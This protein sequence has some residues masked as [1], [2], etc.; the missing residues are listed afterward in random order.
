[1]I[2]RLSHSKAGSYKGKIRR[3]EKGFFQLSSSVRIDQN[4]RLE[5]VM[6]GCTIMTE[7]ISCEEHKPGDFRVGARRTYGPQRAIRS[8]PRVPVNFDAVLKISASDSIRA[9]VVEMSYS[10][11]GLELST[12]IPAGTR[13]FVEFAAGTAF[14]E[15]KHCSPNALT[16]RAG[17]RIDEFVVRKQPSADLLAFPLGTTAGVSDHIAARSRALVLRVVCTVRGHEYIWCDDAWERPVLRC[18]RCR[19]AL[20]ASN[21]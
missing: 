12:A 20:D 19:Q 3:V 14:G 21:R 15:L 4:S 11:L 13:V 10:G 9:K 5:V 16:F 2:L 6:D 17:V 18:T 7:V 8:E 1:M